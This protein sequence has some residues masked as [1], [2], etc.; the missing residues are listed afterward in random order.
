MIC[1]FCQSQSKHR[2]DNI[3]PNRRRVSFTTT[4]IL[5]CPTEIN[6][7]TIFTRLFIAVQF[8]TKW[9]LI[10]THRRYI[11]KILLPFPSVSTARHIT[12]H[13]F[14]LVS[15]T[16]FLNSSNNTGITSSWLATFWL[17][18]TQNE[19]S[20]FKTLILIHSTM[21]DLLKT[22]TN[23]IQIFIWVKIAKWLIA[24]YWQGMNLCNNLCFT[25]YPTLHYY[26][27]C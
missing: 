15:S 19:Y 17:A 4:S 26:P 21:Q 12:I 11:H 23:M 18:P 9:I 20:Y 16:S 2:D 24:K 7:K 10:T 22:L 13:N 14:W 3:A 25:Q 5:L 6:T 27:V 8:V 1:T